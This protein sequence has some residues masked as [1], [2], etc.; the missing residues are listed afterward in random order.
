MQI[1]MKQ[2]YYRSTCAEIKNFN[3]KIKMELFSFKIVSV[4]QTYSKAGDYYYSMGSTYLTP[5]ALSSRDSASS[6]PSAPPRSLRIFA[7]LFMA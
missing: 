4:D 6:R 3:L 1:I 2:V 7:R 5:V